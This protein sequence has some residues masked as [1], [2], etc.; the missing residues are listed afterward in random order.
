MGVLKYFFGF[1]GRLTRFDFWLGVIALV[2][3]G[4]LVVV[5]LWRLGLPRPLASACGDIVVLVLFLGLAVKRGNDRGHAPRDTLLMILAVIGTGVAL[6]L[7]KAIGLATIW[8][9]GLSAVTVALTIIAIV[10]LGFMLPPDAEGVAPAEAAPA[11][12]PAHPISQAGRRD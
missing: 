10:D 7:A 11:L 5:G 9:A 2:T 1:S 12:L 6:S 3:I 8:I 4:W